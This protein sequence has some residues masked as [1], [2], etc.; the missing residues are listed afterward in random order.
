VK[1]EPDFIVAEPAARQ[2]G[3]FDGVLAFLDPLF[4]RATLIV[5]GD[6]PFGGAAQV[7]DD[8]ADAGIQFAVMPLDLGDD[9]TFPVPRSGLVAEAGMEANPT[10]TH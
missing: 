5:E 7:G 4:R 8:E 2:P 1:L 6:D 10:S 9:A 3:P